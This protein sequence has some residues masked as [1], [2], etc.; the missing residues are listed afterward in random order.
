MDASHRIALG[1]ES[2]VI[3]GDAVYEPRATLCTAAGARG[4]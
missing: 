1:L 4:T 3:G 2:R